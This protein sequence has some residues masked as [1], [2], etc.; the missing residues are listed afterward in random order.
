[1]RG[2]TNRTNNLELPRHSK[3][4]PTTQ[5]QARLARCDRHQARQGSVSPRAPV[6]GL[7]HSG[8]LPGAT[9][10]PATQGS[11]PGAVTGAVLHLASPKPMSNGERR[12]RGPW[13]ERAPAPIV[14]LLHFDNDRFRETDPSSH[15]ASRTRLMM[16]TRTRMRMGCL[17]A[18]YPLVARLLP[19]FAGV[20][21]GR[22][23]WLLGWEHGGTV[24][25]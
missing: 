2:T 24:G 17:P 10:N 11:P 25:L 1:M 3:C 12:C 19:G 8:L 21:G 18:C 6:L 9:E 4:L 16:G 7:T 23:P 14:I 15:G 5:L 13:L 22:Q 20:G